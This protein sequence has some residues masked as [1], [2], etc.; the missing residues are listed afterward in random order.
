MS[1]S[2]PLEPQAPLNWAP[3]LVFS[4]TFVAAI[5]LVP[6]WGFTHGFSAG[7]WVVAVLFAG[8][9]GMAI[10]GGYHR[11]WAHKAYDA[12]WSVRLLYMVFGT[13]SLQ[14]SVFVWASNHRTHHLHVDDVDK[15]PY[16]IRRGFW[17]AH[18][19][20]ML[21]EYPSAHTDFSNIPDLRRDPMLQFQHRFYVPLALAT[22]FGLPLLAG[23]L[24]GDLWGTFMLA[25]IVRLVWAHHVTFFINSLAHM[26]GTRPYTDENTARDNP[27]LAVITYGEGYHNYHHIFAHDY[28][29]GVRWWQ[30]DPTKWLIAGLQYVG[31]TS[32]LKR[33]PDFQIQR[34][35]LSMQFKRTQEKLA[36]L[37]AGG[38][39]QIELIRQRIAHEYET[40]H[41]AVAEWAKVKERWLE[42]KARAVVQHWEHTSFQDQLR[43]IERRLYL[44]R[45]RL[46]VLYAQLA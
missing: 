15:D 11:L 39:S 34:A 38:P 36:K 33:T 17:F 26:W 22:N 32:R 37:P 23:W 12:H 1:Q 21:R 2:T 5:T 41:A 29:N 13:M 18:I 4:L 16:S 19:G 24:V 31:L 30:W 9:N 20:W 3:T 44:Q 14:N 25:G 42:E 46:R 6:Y 45:R 8:A 35:L 28:R 10:T 40:F 43:E 7:A 27:V